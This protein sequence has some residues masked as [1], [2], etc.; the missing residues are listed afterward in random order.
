MSSPLLTGRKIWKQLKWQQQVSDYGGWGTL[1]REECV[2]M[3]KDESCVLL[4]HDGTEVGHTE[5]NKSERVNAR[6]SHSSVEFKET[7]QRSIQLQVKRKPVTLLDTKLRL[8][9]GVTR[10]LMGSGIWVGSLW[11]QVMS[12]ITLL[13]GYVQKSG[14]L[15]HTYER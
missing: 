6:R 11:W 8:P 1:T 12:R 15:K 5:W 2:L 13:A 3:R 4:H 7:E 9:K 10:S 14:C